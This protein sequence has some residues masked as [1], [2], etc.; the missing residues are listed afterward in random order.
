MTWPLACVACVL[1][2]LGAALWALRLILASR[3]TV[4]RAEHEALAA[5]LAEVDQRLRMTKL[6]KAMP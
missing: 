2:T 4:T 5:K 6:G 1:A 3:P